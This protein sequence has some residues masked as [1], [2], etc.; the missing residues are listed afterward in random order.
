MART[1]FYVTARSLLPRRW[2]HL[3][4]S[5]VS[6][7]VKVRDR[8]I[9]SHPRWRL[10]M[11]QLWAF[12]A[13]ALPVVAALAS[14][15]STV[16]LAYHLRAGDGI[17]STHALP[18][19]DTYT[20]TV[21]GRPWLDQ[22]WGAQVLLG[23]A[24]RLGGWATLAI[25]RAAMVGAIFFLVYQACRLGG[26][27]IRQ[28]A[29]LTIAS[30]LVATPGLGL[31]PQLFAMVL[32][33]LTLWIVARRGEHPTGLLAIP[34]IVAVWAN[35]HGSFFLPLFLLGIAWLQ[36]RKGSEKRAN[37][38]L[39]VGAASGVATLGNP[40]GPRV[41]AYV[42]NISRNPDITRFVTEWQP[43]TI[44]TYGGAMFFLSV[45][46]IVLFLAR[47]SAATPWPTLIGLGVFFLIALDAQRGVTWWAFAV[48]V[49]IA[50]LLPKPSRQLQG[51][52][53]HHLLNVSI[54]AALVMVGIVY[55]PW[56]RA[57]DTTGGASSL[58]RDDP[59]GITRELHAIAT[60]GERVFN[61]QIWGSWIEFSLPQT[62]AAVD[63][64]I[65]L[66]PASVWQV[67]GDVSAGRQGWQQDLDRWGVHLIVASREQQDRLLP[68]LAGDRSWRLVYADADG[69][70]YK[71]VHD[72]PSHP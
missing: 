53:A 36:D 47:R 42:V 26:A 3:Y 1:Y 30:F 60:P 13:I 28:S 61:A 54:A 62:K 31:R 7:A 50:G 11:P 2:Y 37:K 59:T 68:L 18:Q 12:V 71:R 33:A 15:M 45:A 23:G 57:G 29:A 52:E 41:W 6:L 51:R 25:A 39:W 32:F 66:F 64:R 20:F 69:A 40:F 43:P 67:Y 10:S 70:I 21:A 65:E 63:S 22:Q 46:L 55:L 34:P 14:H 56:W 16:D 58:L 19:V 72:A 5:R 48:P 49:L 44:R 38:L 35:L 27:S 4:D 24:Y 17:L 8:E 9:E